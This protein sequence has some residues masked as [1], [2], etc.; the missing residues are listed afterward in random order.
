MT[1]QSFSRATGL[2]TR[3]LRFSN[4]SANRLAPRQALVTARKA[5]LTPVLLRSRFLSTTPA[6]SRG[7]LPDT[8]DPAP[9]NVQDNAPKAV[10]AELNDTEY[11]ELADEYIDVILSRLEEVG[12]KD[13]GVDVEY[14][15]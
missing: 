13:E 3:A 14:A 8:D 12:E 7:I 9:P 5:V 10:P 15:V 11:H 4:I 6:Q 1:R 2:V